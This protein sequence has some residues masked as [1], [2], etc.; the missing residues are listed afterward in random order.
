MSFKIGDVVI[1]KHGQ[2][3]MGIY[4]GTYMVRYFDPDHDG[5]F[6][7]DYIDEDK[8]QRDWKHW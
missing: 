3:I 7:I 1:Y 4:V 2:G 5:H 8:L 6:N